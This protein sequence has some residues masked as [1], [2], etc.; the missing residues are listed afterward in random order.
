[1]TASAE[2]AGSAVA[3]TEAGALGLVAAD[4]AALGLVAAVLALAAPPWVEGDALDVHPTTS[5]VAARIVNV[6][7]NC[8]AV[9][10]LEVLLDM[11]SGRGCGPRRRHRRRAPAP[12][13]PALWRGHSTDGF[14]CD[15]L[16]RDRIE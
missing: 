1:M 5:I 10:L 3:A 7:F 9:L 2:S 8:T 4:A 14:A 6:R 13:S 12:H 15:H 11:A 16:L